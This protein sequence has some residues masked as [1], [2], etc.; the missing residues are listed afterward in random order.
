MLSR[1]EFIQGNMSPFVREVEQG[2][3]RGV[4]T[5][6]FP[7]RRMTEGQLKVLVDTLSAKGW[8]VNTRSVVDYPDADY[9]SSGV[10]VASYIIE[11]Y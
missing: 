8:T 1:D 10:G 7:K 3:R 4:T 11:V 6:T 9:T 2:L 5:F